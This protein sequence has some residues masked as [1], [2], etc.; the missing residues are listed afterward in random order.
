MA[1]EGA[2]NSFDFIARLWNEFAKKMISP[3]LERKYGN[4]DLALIFVLLLLLALLLSYAV[5]W[6]PALSFDA[7]SYEELQEQASPQFDWLMRAVSDLGEAAIALMLTAL[8]MLTFALRRQWLEAVF[9]LATTSS[10]LLAFVIKELIHRT[11]PF[12]LNQNATNILHTINEYS[13][14]SGHVLFYVVFFGL[15]AYLA[16]KNFAGR[17]RVIIIAIC[18]ALIVLIGPSRI[19]LGAHWASDV[20]GSYIFGTI[21]LLVLILAYKWAIRRKYHDYS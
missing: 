18:S 3:I 5:A 21:L 4:R 8:A 14:P 17:A 9:M 2:L 13:Y 15:F 11:R 1:L 20:L 10:V 16:W 19:F 6:S 12:P 7:K